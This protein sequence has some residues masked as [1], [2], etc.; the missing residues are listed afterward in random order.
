MVTGDHANSDAGVRALGDGDH[1]LGSGGI[2]LGEL[3]TEDL[4]TITAGDMRDA[5]ST[6]LGGLRLPV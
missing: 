3:T 6:V 2:D 1:R 5:L 4:T